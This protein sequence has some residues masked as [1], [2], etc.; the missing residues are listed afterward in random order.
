MI[1]NF[2]QKLFRNIERAQ[3][4]RAQQVMKAYRLGYYNVD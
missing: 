3:T 2:L 4:A 1:L